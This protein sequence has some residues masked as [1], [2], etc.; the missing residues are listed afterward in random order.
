MKSIQNR[1]EDRLKVPANLTKSKPNF[2]R[3]ELS[4]AKDWIKVLG[5]K[6]KIICYFHTNKETFQVIRSSVQDLVTEHNQSFNTPCG[7]CKK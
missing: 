1:M 4:I 5:G 6:G 7:G 2:W 3:F